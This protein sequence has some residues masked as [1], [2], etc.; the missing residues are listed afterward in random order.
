M[1]AL[2]RDYTLRIAG[3]AEALLLALVL[4]G[5]SDILRQYAA[6]GRCLYPTAV[7]TF[8][9][10]ILATIAVVH[11]IASFWFAKRWRGA[12]RLFGVGLV[13]AAASALAV[14]IVGLRIGV[15]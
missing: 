2:K 5:M 13:A 3:I 8:Y 11:A 9:T 14:L 7:R 4:Y 6:D 10:L 15:F 12:V 1:H